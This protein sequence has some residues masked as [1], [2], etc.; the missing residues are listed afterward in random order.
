MDLAIAAKHLINSEL[1]KR[2]MN[3]QELAEKLKE[4]GFEVTSRIAI[5]NKI[6]RGTFSTIFFLECM[7]ALG[8]KNIS[9]EDLYQK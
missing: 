3:K 9:L 7:T 8:V 1:S 6:N 4:A 2:N 5:T